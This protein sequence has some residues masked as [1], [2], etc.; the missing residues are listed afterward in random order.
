AEDVALP[1]DPLRAR[2]GV[3]LDPARRISGVADS[4]GR[5]R[6]VFRLDEIMPSWQFVIEAATAV[7]ATGAKLSPS[8]PHDAPPLGTEAQWTSWRGEVLECVVWWGPLVH[9]AG[10]TAQ[11]LSP[12]R[13]PVVVDET[14]AEDDPPTTRSHTAL[15]PWLYESDR[16]VTRAGLLGALTAATGG[17]EIE[18]GLGYVTAEREVDVPFARRFRV[19][20]AMPYNVKVLRGWLRERHITDLTIKKRGLRLDEE[21]LRR[22]LRVGRTAGDGES[23]TV[24]LTRVAGEP[25]AIIVERAG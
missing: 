3:W 24:L 18:A 13:S 23:A 9:R 10:R 7:P 1:V 8:L 5:T 11:L 14:M 21:Q 6:R 20:E 2:A 25:M 19:L 4:R 15:G 22:Q 16:A 12:D 17:T